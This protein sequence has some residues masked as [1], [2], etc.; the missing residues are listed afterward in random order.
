MCGCAVRS[1]EALS[2]SPLKMMKISTHAA[3]IRLD[4]SIICSLEF[5]SCGGMGSELAAVIG[6]QL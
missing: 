2:S 6:M 3:A 4:A 1:T 5:L